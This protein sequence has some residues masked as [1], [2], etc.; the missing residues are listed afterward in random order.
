MFATKA[1]FCFFINRIISREN[2]KVQVEVILDI[3]N[4][5]DDQSI[6]DIGIQF[7]RK[8]RDNEDGIR[9]R[10]ALAKVADQ[11]EFFYGSDDLGITTVQFWL[12]WHIYFYHKLLNIHRNQLGKFPI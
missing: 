11:P 12:K 10:G 5:Q 9:I 3:D 8:L 6:T 2:G 4:V 7:R 1:L